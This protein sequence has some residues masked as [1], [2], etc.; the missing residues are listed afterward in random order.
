MLSHTISQIFFDIDNELHQRCP[1]GALYNE[2][3][4]Y[5]KMVTIG[6]TIRPYKNGTDFDLQ[7]DKYEVTVNPH[8]FKVCE[9]I[10]RQQDEMLTP[11][12]LAKVYTQPAMREKWIFEINNVNT[13]HY[14]ASPYFKYTA[15]PYVLTEE[16]FFQ[17]STLHD[18]GEMKLED[19][20]QIEEFRLAVLKC[21][22]Q[23]KRG[24]LWNN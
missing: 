1:Y 6:G 7:F 5:E 20:L 4:M 8:T 16:E 18:F 2:L 15:H 13:I 9:I 12:G 11:F 3:S 21:V 10:N 23:H 24:T 14:Y 22:D 17:E 19:M